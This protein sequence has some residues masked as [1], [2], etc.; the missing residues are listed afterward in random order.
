[1]RRLLITLLACLLPTV[2]NAAGS[3]AD[4]QARPRHW[5]N[6]TWM[7]RV[8]DRTLALE[9]DDVRLELRETDPPAPR[10]IDPKPGSR[11]VFAMENTTVYVRDGKGA[12]HPLR[13]ARAIDKKYPA[14]GGGHL[15]RAVSGDGRVVTL[16]DGSLWEISPSDYF[17]TATWQAGA[18]MTV[19]RL[20]GDDG[21]GYELDNN[22]V[23]EGA[24][25]SYQVKR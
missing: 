18:V 9:T 16:E 4:L 12:E 17:K 8:D 10:P 20:A 5:Q 3:R 22:D 23:D 6:G 19:V 11:A 14:V 25:A 21:F 7:A 2:A 13:I 15:L 1:M 24:L